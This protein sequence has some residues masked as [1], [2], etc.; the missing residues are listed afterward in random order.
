MNIL[1]F[2]FSLTIILLLQGCV[3]IGLRGDVTSVIDHPVIGD[4]GTLYI[5]ENLSKHTSKQELRSRWGQPDYIDFTDDISERWDYILG[6]R[7][8]GLEIMAV[9]LPLPL[10]VPVGREHIYFF[11]TNEEMMHSEILTDDLRFYAGCYLFILHAENP[12]CETEMLPRVVQNKILNVSKP[13][14]R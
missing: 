1:R 2:V 13:T 5:G 11:F 6:Y 4:K 14:T 12:G 3:G 10:L 9:V 7:W 8:N